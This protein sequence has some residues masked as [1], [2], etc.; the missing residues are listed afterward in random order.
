MSRNRISNGA[1]ETEH[2][3]TDAP[4]CDR[5]AID[6]ERVATV[7]PSDVSPPA[8]CPYCSQPFPTER[9]CTLHLGE[10]H[11]E[12]WTDDERERYESVSDTEADEL[13]IFH[14]KVIGALVITFFGFSYIYVFVW[15]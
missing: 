8:Q 4:A 12:E 6:G 1:T 5:R 10:H 2:R 11:R 15:S 13:F 9:L 14:M 7:V 3:S